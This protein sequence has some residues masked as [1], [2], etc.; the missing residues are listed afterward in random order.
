MSMPS[1]RHAAD[2]G[3][4]YFVSMT[5]LMVGVLF[6]FII[7]LMYFVLQHK[8]LAEKAQRDA[9]HAA[10]TKQTEIQNLEREKARYTDIRKVRDKILREIKS[11]LDRNFGT[12]VRIDF[13]VGIVRLPEDVLFDSGQATLSAGAQ[14][15][16]KHLARALMSVLPCYTMGIESSTRKCDDTPAYVEAVFIE[17]HTDKVALSPSPQLKDNL[18]LSAIRATNTFRALLNENPLL[19][20]LESPC[21]SP[22]VTETGQP[23]RRAPVLSVSG[24]GE[25]R[26]AKLYEPGEEEK[27]E[28]RRI[29]LRILMA[30]PETPETSEAP[31]TQSVQT[32]FASERE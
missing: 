5:D 20:S 8:G 24:Y 6:V 16:V 9:E 1:R 30:T 10:K 31:G 4:D 2:E 28:N 17:G 23:C 13:D 32:D 14:T 18:D 26:P 3:E 19:L 25:Y 27:A 12:T 11:H 29:D 21:L 15:A 7:M 22:A